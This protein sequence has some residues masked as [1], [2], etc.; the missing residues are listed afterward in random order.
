MS[1][2]RP[3]SPLRLL[4]LAALFGAAVHAAP[5]RAEID[6]AT[7]N[8]FAVGTGATAF[9]WLGEANEPLLIADS[10]G[11]HAW[12][13]TGGKLQ[14]GARSPAG[15][16]A[17]VLAVGP[18]PANGARPVAFASRDSARI[19]IAPLGADGAVGPAALI[20]LP[21]LPRAAVVAPISG[22]A[23]AAVFVAHDDGLSV[24]QQSGD[25]WRRRELAG[26]PFASDLAAVANRDGHTDLIAADEASNQLYWLRGDG[27][28]G[29]E[30][31]APIATQRRP[32]RVVAADVS[33]DGRADLLVLGEDGLTVHRAG[34]GGFLAGES[35]WAVPHL[36]DAAVGDINGDG[37]VDLAVVDRSRSTVTIL[38]AAPSGGFTLGE[39]YLAGT[40]P[41]RLLLTDVD[42]DGRLD[43]LTLNLL[44]DS[45]T[46]LRGRG[47]G[48]F[49]GIAG[50]RGAL[51]DLT[52]AV[53]GDFNRDELP[54][55]A[56]ASE[57]GGRIGIL[58]GR[59]DGGFTVLPPLTV[60]R[61]PRALAVGDFN[62][63]GQVDLAVVNFGSDA[64]VILAGDGR[65]GF[66]APRAIAVGVGP[67][68]ITTGSFSSPT[69]T[70][71]AIVNSLSDSVSVLYGDGRGQFPT[72]A[73][74]PV[75]ARPSFLIVGDTN[76]DGNQDLVVGSE[77]SESVA[78]L[79][80]T[81]HQLDAPTTNKLSGTARPS[82][83]EDFDRDGQMDLVN[84]DESGGRIEILPGTAPGEFGPPLHIMVGRDPRAVATGDFDRDGRIDLAVVHRNT[85]TI[86]I[87]LN[88]SPTNLPPKPTKR[89]GAT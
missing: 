41:E 53:V 72:V 9:I 84:P 21:A 60:G 52:A 49:D 69:A 56:V 50:V 73:T 4:A 19:A 36:A 6:F 86:A 29:F 85:Q 45:T 46:L 15:G 77:F 32:R 65:G 24:L 3:R 44:A 89:G 7:R 63:D 88:R 79:L 39:T 34:P 82:V 26:P 14:R 1:T 35:I 57:D 54:D 16:G 61:Q 23:E 71:L 80:G 64:V 48:T 43:A 8:D 2:R 68:A 70:D 55:L 17:R 28:G 10:E 37:R 40:G 87:L 11:L 18:L 51:G 12:R 81:G 78:I 30:P 13:L 67:S 66:A 83:A 75:A 31:A 27:V 22:G 38:L 42:A 20:G 33:G 74:F 58:L 5:V 47:D 25:T 62:Q 59:G 76:R